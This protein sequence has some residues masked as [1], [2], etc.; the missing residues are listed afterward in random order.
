MQSVYS[1][2]KN[3]AEVSLAIYRPR[4]TSIGGTTNSMR[5]QFCNLEILKNKMTCGGI[6]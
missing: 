5:F 2:D 4:S 6:A 1:L 3:C